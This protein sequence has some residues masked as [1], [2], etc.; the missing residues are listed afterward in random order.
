MPT[1]H[2][3]ENLLIES[4][5]AA[6]GIFPA[7]QDVA[8]SGILTQISETSMPHVRKK[9]AVSKAEDLARAWRL[10]VSLAFTGIWWHLQEPSGAETLALNVRSKRQA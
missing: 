9:L 7:L 1:L 3:R 8:P 4:R 6:N 2:A 10:T 5:K